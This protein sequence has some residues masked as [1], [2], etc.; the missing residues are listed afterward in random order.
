MKTE[1]Q[2][3]KLKQEAVLPRYALEGDVAFDLFSLEDYLLQ[4]GE[5]YL[6]KIGLA[7][8]IPVRFLCHRQTQIGLSGEGGD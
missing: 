2:F 6:F 7:S 1:L 3:K 8:Q 4:P 5:K